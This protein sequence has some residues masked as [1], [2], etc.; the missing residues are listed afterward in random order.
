MSNSAGPSRRYHLTGSTRRSHLPLHNVGVADVAGR[1]DHLV[2]GAEV[3]AQARLV[4]HEATAEG[5]AEHLERARLAARRG[6]QADVRHQ[7]LLV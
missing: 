4:L 7:H 2:G 1:H 3:A 5:A 6:V